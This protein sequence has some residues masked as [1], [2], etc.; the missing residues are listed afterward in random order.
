MAAEVEVEVEVEA[1]DAVGAVGAAVVSRVQRVGLGWRPELAAGIFANLDRIDVVEVLADDYFNAPRR[2]RDA[3]RAL[4]EQVPVQLHGV[5][6]GLASACAVDTARLDRMARLVEHVRPAGWSEHLAFVRA[7]GVEIGHLAMPPRTARTIEQ[8]VRNVELART[9]TGTVPA[10]ENI[11][12]LF[13]PPMSTHTEADWSRQ[14]LVASGAP[15]LLDLHN[16]YAN[17][18][19]ARRDPLADL[20]AFP[21]ERVSGV[22]LSGGM[23]ISHDGGERRLLDDHLHS[24]PDAVFELLRSLQMQTKASFDVVLERDGRYPKFEVLIGELDRA[25]AALSPLVAQPLRRYA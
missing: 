5:G 14:I 6:L 10:L 15:L 18:V 24:P 12:T 21:L 19:N 2:E 7:K 9:I 3:L 25:R 11:A 17:A 13:D 1:A 20:A 22:H 8:T 4:A 16:L 23:W